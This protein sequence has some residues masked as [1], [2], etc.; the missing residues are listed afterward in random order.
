MK[1][2]SPAVAMLF[3]LIILIAIL[4]PFTYLMFSIPTSTV[5]AENQAHNNEEL[6]DEQLSEI[7]VIY[8]SYQLASGIKTFYG[9]VY[10]GNFLYVLIEEQNP[11]VP[12]VIKSIEGLQGTTWTVVS[13]GQ[14]TITTNNTVFDGIPA[15]KI[16][17]GKYSEIAVETNLGNIINVP[18]YKIITPSRVSNS[19]AIISLNE[20]KFNVLQSPNFYPLCCHT[21][22]SRIINEFGNSFTLFGL[23]SITFCANTFFKVFYDGKLCSNYNKF[24][25]TSLC[26]TFCI[27]SG[28]VLKTTSIS[29]KIEIPYSFFGQSCIKICKAND[30]CFCISAAC[31]SL[32]CGYANITFPNGKTEILKGSLQISPSVTADVHVK[33]GTVIIKP[34]C[35]FA[36][37]IVQGN[38]KGKLV[39][40]SASSSVIKFICVN[41]GCTTICNKNQYPLIT[42]SGAIYTIFCNF[43]GTLQGNIIK[44]TCITSFTSVVL[45][46]PSNCPYINYSAIKVSGYLLTPIKVKINFNIYNPGNYSLDV[47]SIVM[48]FQEEFILSLTSSHSGYESGCAVGMICIPYSAVIP[49]GGLDCICEV[50]SIP[51]QI[52]FL[53]N[54]NLYNEHNYSGQLFMPTYETVTIELRTNLGYISSGTFVI[55]VQPPYKVY[56]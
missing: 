21:P 20:E 51:V 6:A 37:A 10:S 29:G 48:L 2:L 41:T 32:S 28:E 35:L 23:S 4:I 30:T 43:Y 27:P 31:I 7:E 26:G 12:L 24:I 25:F 54:P 40:F 1:A 5:N 42:L 18:E 3:V 34:F 49:P 8:N 16:P 22:L 52:H 44:G 50:I 55:P 15:Y 38:L 14:I 56:T 17:V 47:N 45:S 11:P 53:G 39:E 46:I 36:A 33:N 19:S 13:S 9:L